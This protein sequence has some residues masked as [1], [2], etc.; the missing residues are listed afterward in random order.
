[1]KRSSSSNKIFFPLFLFIRNEENKIQ[2][3]QEQDP[4]G[5][6]PGGVA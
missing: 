6:L 1:M 3:V 2:E 5:S 4:H